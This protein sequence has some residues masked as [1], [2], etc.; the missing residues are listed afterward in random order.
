MKTF[1]VSSTSDATLSHG[2]VHGA[3]AALWTAAQA[4][5]LGEGAAVL[6]LICEPDGVLRPQ[7]RAPLDWTPEGGLRAAIGAAADQGRAATRPAGSGRVAV[8]LA[9]TLDSGMAVAGAV[10]TAVD[11]PATRLALQRLGWGMAG[12]EAYLRRIAGSAAPVAADTGATAATLGALRLVLRALETRGYRDASRT[13]ATELALA[14]RADRV[15]IARR[16][17]R[18]ARIEALSHVAGFFK[19]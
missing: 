9:L 14:L 19:S 13:A 7:G 16:R 2:S 11:E 17:R 1:S 6:L 15:A 5:E 10:V 8:A 12:V 4:R 18:G 3:F